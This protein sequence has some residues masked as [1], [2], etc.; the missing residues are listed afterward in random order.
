MFVS[1]AVKSK[2]YEHY[3]HAELMIT[4]DGYFQYALQKKISKY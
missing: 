4:G 1:Y 2:N 3:K